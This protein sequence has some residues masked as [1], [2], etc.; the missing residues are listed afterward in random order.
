MKKATLIIL[1]SLF[2]AQIQA[3]AGD[4]T[5]YL[6]IKE[7]VVT[8]SNQTAIVFEEGVLT[9]FVPRVC[10]NIHNIIDNSTEQ[11]KTMYTLV[12]AAHINDKKIKIATSS[13]C[14]NNGTRPLV[15]GV[16]R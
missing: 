7:L 16:I 2:T 11:G 8:N 1:F 3:A 10:A 9:G 4:W 13:N 15:I 12:L 5:G 14:T 6:T